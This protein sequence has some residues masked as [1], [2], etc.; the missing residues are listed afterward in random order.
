M[1]F[2]IK[3]D[4]GV[5][6]SENQ[7]RA[8]VF[9]NDEC[10]FAILCD[11]MGGHT[12]GSYA[13]SITVNVFEKEFAKG[14]DL[15]NVSTWFENGIKRSKREMIDFANGDEK[16]LDMGTT[17]TAALI[18]KNEV[19]IFNIG[20]SRT[21]AFNGL[22]HQLTKDHNL[23]NHYIDKFGYTPEEA[24]KV[25]G[26][27]ALTSALG[28]QKTTHA[29]TFILDRDGIQYLVLTSDGVHDYIS[30]PAFETILSSEQKIE[31]K[32]E[33]LI[34]KAIRGKSS[35]NLTAVIVDLGEKW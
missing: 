26:A 32:A 1:K 18:T 5:V 35:D 2:T 15:K 10:T 7:D 27:S 11:G 20:D 14:V 33:E 17:V 4:V 9:S 23:W 16:L 31:G 29:D 25:M 28:P 24:A 30:K 34:L 8:A 12:G 19:F 21:Y 3:T 6:R 22:L 13:S